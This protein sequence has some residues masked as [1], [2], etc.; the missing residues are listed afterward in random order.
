MIAHHSRGDV[1]LAIDGRIVD[2]ARQVDNPLH[3]SRCGGSLTYTVLRHESRGTLSLIVSDLPSHGLPLYYALAAVGIF[4]VG[5]SVREN[6]TIRPRC[7][8]FWLCVAF[9]GV[10]SLSYSG[11]LDP[12]TTSSIGETRWRA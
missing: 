3:A 11:R 1:L 7:T 4:I 5:G 12:W 10:M 6:Q 8:F 9:F 2:S